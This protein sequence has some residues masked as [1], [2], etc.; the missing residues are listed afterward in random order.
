MTATA[1]RY[2][3]LAYPLAPQ[4]GDLLHEVAAGNP[5]LVLQNL[6][7]GWMPRWHYAVVVGYDLSRNEV[8]LR[9]GTHRRWI[10]KLSAFQNTWRR[11]NRWALVI[12]PAGEIPATATPQPYLKASYELEQTGKAEAAQQA[13]AAATRRWPQDKRVWL[14]S[15]NNAYG[16]KRY[17]EAQATLLRAAKLDVD[18]PVIWNNLA[19]VY[20]AA[21]CPA[22]ARQAVAH[23]LQL[24]PEDANLL[25]SQREIKDQSA[26]LRDS[27]CTLAE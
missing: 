20:L 27:S 17:Q 23:A 6:G 2:G 3:Q 12:L 5:V 16:L 26:G 9:S 14:A 25:D 18:D 21:G 1:R 7:F 15:A 4:L 8:I 10:S 13:Y 11:A 19:Y 24:K 22:Q